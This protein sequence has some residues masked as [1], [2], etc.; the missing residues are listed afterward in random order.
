[1]FMFCMLKIKIVKHQK[2]H[3][4]T[5]NRVYVLDLFIKVSIAV[6]DKISSDVKVFTSTSARKTNDLFLGP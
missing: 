4:G 5:D 1:M 2:I 3:I 6:N